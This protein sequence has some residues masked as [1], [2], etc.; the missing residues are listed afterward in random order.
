MRYGA[1]VVV[2]G[3]VGRAVVVVET[4]GTVVV[5]GLFGIQGGSVVDE[6]G[7]VVPVPLV[8][9]VVL[10]TTVVVVVAPM[11]VVVVP[12]VAVLH[13][14]D[15]SSEVKIPATPGNPAKEP[16]SDWT[17]WQIGSRKDGSSWATG[18]STA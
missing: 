11:L 18:V 14:R 3:V 10:G 9:V 7:V 6:V 17:S 15:C 16:C 2:D 4:H 13:P 5:E 1:V 8:V 12:G